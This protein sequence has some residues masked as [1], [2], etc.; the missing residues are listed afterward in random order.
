MWHVWRTGKM[1]TGFWWGDLMERGHMK[2]LGIDVRIILKWIL[3]VRWGVRRIYLA[4][5]RDR[6]QLL[7]KAVMYFQVPENRRNFVTS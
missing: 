3:V 2:D 5:D 1:R 4:R 6:W 7:V